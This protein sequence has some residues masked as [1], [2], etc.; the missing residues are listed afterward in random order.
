MDP[1]AG[2][3]GK[4]VLFVVLA[5]L[6]WSLSGVF[7]RSLPGLTGWQ[8]N[9]WRGLATSL[10]L[11][12][13][14][15]VVYRG[16]LWRRLTEIPPAAMLLCACFFALGSTLYVTALS[17]TSTANVSCIGSLAPIFAA[18]MSPVVTGER[19]PASAFVAALLAILGVSI[20]V[21]DGLGDGNWR[22]SVAALLVALCF[23]IQ[24]LVLRRYRSFDLVPAICLGGF[25]VFGIAAV[26]GNGLD[27]PPQSIA[28]LS[29]MGVVQLAVPLIFFVRSAQHL[30]AVTITLLAMTDILLN[31]LWA[32]VGMGEVP[33][34]MTWIGGGVMVAAILIGVVWPAIQQPAPIKEQTAA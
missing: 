26:A 31:P 13:F 10:F 5:N 9:C 23:A 17:V 4:G 8:L 1:K 16:D 24:T 12:A 25:M 18:L 33:V 20:I 32:Y 34:P 2:N 14:L 28:T 21:W 15:V 29:L 19:P 22:G 11:G 30:P 7:V 3:F 27:V 6:G